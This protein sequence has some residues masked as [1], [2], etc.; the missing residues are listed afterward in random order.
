MRL[1]DDLLSPVLIV[2]YVPT[3]GA[4]HPEEL[5]TDQFNAVIA[6]SGSGRFLPH[7][8]GRR[9]AER[10]EEVV[11]VEHITHEPDRTVIPTLHAGRG[12]LKVHHY[13]PGEPDLDFAGKLRAE[14][15]AASARLLWFGQSPDHEGTRLLMAMLAEAAPPPRANVRVLAELPGAV[16]ATFADF[17]SEVAGEGF[18]FVHERV[19]SGLL[20]SPILVVVDDGRIVGAIGPMETLAN[21]AGVPRLLPQYFAVLPDCRGRGFGRD[22]WRAACRWGREHGAVYQVMQARSGGPSERLF[23]SEGLRT[24]GFIFTAAL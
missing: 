23:V 2:P 22:L 21:S 11:L 18:G 6:A 15:G 9:W 4:V 16:L 1:R 8:A 5:T 17:A 3:L 24:L 13:G 19:V 10:Q 12:V 20:T 14:Y 7:D